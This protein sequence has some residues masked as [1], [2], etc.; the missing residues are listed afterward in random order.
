MKDAME[1]MNPLSEAIVEI[2][3]ANPK[4][5]FAVIVAKLLERG[6]TPESLSEKLKQYPIADIAMV[7]AR[8]LVKKNIL[9]RDEERQYSCIPPST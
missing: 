6:F 9:I 1:E 5:K 2:V 3:K 4:C 7:C 8:E